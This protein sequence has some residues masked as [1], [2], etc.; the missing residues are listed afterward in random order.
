MS[1]ITSLTIYRPPG[2][3][4]GSDAHYMEIRKHYTLTTTQEY[5]VMGN[6]PKSFF[7]YH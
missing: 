3:R 2:P 1:V 5:M 6:D 4:Q 7:P